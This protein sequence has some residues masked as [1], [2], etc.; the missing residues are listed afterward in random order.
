[1]FVCHLSRAWTW[2]FQN[3]LLHYT[4]L[5]NQPYNTA[6]PH[7]HSKASVYPIRSGSKLEEHYKFIITRTIK[8]NNNDDDDDVKDH[9]CGNLTSE[10]NLDLPSLSPAFYN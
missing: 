8:N 4:A 6:Q 5:R 3:E 10:E 2:M 7:Q 9:Y 1:M